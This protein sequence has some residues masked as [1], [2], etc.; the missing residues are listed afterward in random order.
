VATFN[1]RLFLKGSSIAVVGAGVMT[2]LPGLPA[3]LGVGQAEAPAA[4][5]EAAT[6]GESTMS[7]A[8]PVVAR[9]R[10]AVTGEVD[11]FFGTNSVTTRD[12]ELVAR[13]L[14]AA[15]P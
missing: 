4:E 6:A 3:A 7:M 15:V 5:T 9:V 13:L 11:L 8:E 14:R 2:S 12:P 1:R 10:D